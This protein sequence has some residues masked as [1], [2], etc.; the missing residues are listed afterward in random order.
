VKTGDEAR[1][2][3]LHCPEARE[4]AKYEAEEWF[5]PDQVVGLRDH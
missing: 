4:P 3:Q 2:S 1:S 5:G